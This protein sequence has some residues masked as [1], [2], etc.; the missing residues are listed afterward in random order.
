M[1]SLQRESQPIIFQAKYVEKL[2]HLINIS[3][4]Q[5]NLLIFL[6]TGKLQED[7]K[8]DAKFRTFRVKIEKVKQIYDR[9]LK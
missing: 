6:Q 9:I 7:K 4:V 3:T 5:I 8:E 1:I 2:I